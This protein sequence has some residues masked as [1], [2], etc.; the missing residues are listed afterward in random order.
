MYDSTLTRRLDSLTCS[1]CCPKTDTDDAFDYIKH[2]Q[3]E[4]NI[5]SSMRF[6]ARMNI[7]LFPRQK[8]TQFVLGTTKHILPYFV[9]PEHFHVVSLSTQEWTMANNCKLIRCIA[10]ARPSVIRVVTTAEKLF[11]GNEL[12]VTG[13]ELCILLHE[14]KYRLMKWT[15]AFNLYFLFRPDISIDDMNKLLDLKTLGGNPDPWQPPDTHA[16]FEGY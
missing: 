8:R 5:K 7:P 4:E 14:F 9:F 2:W 11:R 6:A 13:R 16:T 15:P 1:A 10:T 12:T 3:Q